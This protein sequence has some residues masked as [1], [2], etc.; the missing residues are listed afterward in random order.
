MILVLNLYSA[1][2]II[3]S[4]CCF[5]PLSDPQKE[6]VVQIQFECI[7]LNSID[8]SSPHRG[9]K[10]KDVRRPIHSGLNLV[11]ERLTFL[12]IIFGLEFLEPQRFIITE[13]PGTLGQRH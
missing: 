1:L 9:L 5:E 2:A 12:S 13:H 7:P 10:K 3:L 6:L 4:G 11:S 8:D